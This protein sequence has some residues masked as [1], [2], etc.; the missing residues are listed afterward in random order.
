MSIKEAK[1]RIKINK[2]LE[3]AGWRF[4][5]E[6]GKPANIQVEPNVKISK[7][8]VDDMGEN[9]DKIKN[10]F[11][12][13]LLLDDKGHPFI[14]LEA[15]S[16]DKDPLVGKE[17]A[18]EYAK[19]LF[20]KYVILSNGNQH[21]FWNIYK[22]NPQIITSFPNCES[23]RENKAFNADPA[24][25]Y[26]EDVREDYI[27]VVKNPRYTEA[28][29]YQ[30][31]ETRIKFL[32]DSGLRFLR[33]YQLNAVKALQK[34]V[35]KG[36]QRFL[37]EMATGTGKTLTA[38]AI[39]RLFL[40]SGNAHRI[41]FLVDRIELE[42]QAKKNFQNY[43]SPDYHTVVFKENTEDW[44]KAE[45][46]VS[47]VQT[48]MFNN[49]YKKYFKPTDFSLVIVD[50]S[51]R[52]INGNYRAVFEY[53]LGYKLGLTATPKDYIKNVDVSKLKSTDP[54]AWEKRQLL[55]SYKTFGCESGEPTYRYSLLDGVKDGY[56]INPTVVD[57]RTDIT[58][59]L[60]AE[61]GYAVINQ[62]DDNDDEEE[63]FF[64]KDF[65][66]KFFS[67]ETNRMFVKT[68]MENA[69][70]DPLSGEIGKS[71]IFCV[72]RKHAAKITQIL[73]EF[74][75]KLFPDKYYSD[76]AIQIT[77]DV[78][79]AQTFTTNFQNN[80]LSG[81]TKFLDNYKSS[82]TRI[83]ITVGM[84]TTGYDCEDLL[85]IGLLR[86]IFSPTDFIQIKGR[87]T[88]KFEF[89]YKEKMPGA[90][91]EH[92]ADKDTFKLFD[93]FG[94]CEYFEEKFNYDEVIT[95]PKQQGKGTDITTPPVGSTTY[96][97]YDPDP[98]KFIMETPIGFEGMKID[99]MFF[100]KFESK[101]KEDE[102]AKEQYE[103][104]NYVAVQNYIEEKIMNKPSEYYTWDKI[105]RSIGTDRRV[106]VKE[107]LDK[108]F[109][110]IPSFKSK[111]ELIEDEFESY[112][113]TRPVPTDKYTEIKRFFETYIMDKDVRRII[114]DE[115][116]QLLGT[117]VSTYTMSDLKKLG[118]ENMAQVVDYINDNVNVSKFVA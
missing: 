37:F 40:R 57:A 15:K 17:Q 104:G 59:Q 83:C 87:G 67:E 98:L 61:E 71:I 54:R 38:A 65:E 68:F 79:N 97:N 22:G 46:V 85:N 4:F 43:L 112:L 60:L 113:L 64:A 99:R 53:F 33:A 84:M 28:P 32:K 16:E 103:Q 13:F 101:V 47:T 19:S 62:A 36:N 35:K 93:F 45:V 70:R 26:N 89:S 11:I 76:F 39:I 69:K 12:D 63:I 56:L 117:E 75:D 78:M 80:N 14:V 106:T 30:N 95:L 34:S 111:R 86:P 29:E 52:S 18:R 96:E 92:K 2:L 100:D 109:G 118:I 88:R 50:E 110:S 20:I 49:K 81:T 42:N 48:L 82:K 3:E 73:N 72:S 8:Q 94:N 90:I 10:G 21:Y 55:D 115:K 1:A 66:R 5:D 31:P 107:I 58:T 9:F 41:L 27:A 6:D 114:E 105:K 91:M 51:H 77:S 24:R 7:K 116:Y 25:L 23:I 102:T 44:R 108:I 74:A